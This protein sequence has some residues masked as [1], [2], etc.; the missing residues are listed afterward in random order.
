VARRE[1]IVVGA[2]AGGLNPLMQILSDLPAELPAS[3]FVVSHLSTSGNG[4]LVSVL[5]R[6]G[7]LRVKW[8]E[9]REAVEHG[10]VYVAP[11]NYHLLLNE[12]QVRVLFGPRE[13]GSRPAADVLFRSAAAAY[14]SRVI[15]V[16][17]S[18]K[19]DDGSCG[20]RAIKQCGGT[21]VVMDPSH[22]EEPEMPQNALREVE[23]DHCVAP[24]AIGPLLRELVQQRVA[25]RAAVPEEIAIENRIAQAG[26]TEGDDA[27]GAH[28]DSFTC[29]E[30]GGEL[31]PFE[32]G[33][34]SYRCFLGHAYGANSLLDAQ[35]KQV[36][37]ALWVA[38]RALTDRKRILERMAQQYQEKGWSRMA[39]SMT[40]RVNEVGK[41]YELLRDVL[42]DLVRPDMADQG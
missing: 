9:D 27:P 38:L 31:R 24:D 10:T 40:E 33:D 25:P 18:G 17:L 8:A 19:L 2:S 13:C 42:T 30:C 16:V 37:Q 41:Q 28:G 7:P 4:H 29:P 14:N 22:A 34:G 32:S 23:V 11:A 39:H 26:M 20:L 35:R 12:G 1:I 6:S 3:V 15:G 36:E 5:S 21:A